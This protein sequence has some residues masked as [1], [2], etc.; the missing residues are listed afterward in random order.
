MEALDGYGA[1]AFPLKNGENKIT[2][3]C[4]HS[5]RYNPP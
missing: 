1:K 2:T 4:R 3:Y 5:Y